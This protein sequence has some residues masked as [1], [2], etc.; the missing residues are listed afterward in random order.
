ML[1]SSSITKSKRINSKKLRFDLNLQNTC[2]DYEITSALWWRLLADDVDDLG[3]LVEDQG[4][5]GVLDLVPDFLGVL[6]FGAEKSV[7]TLSHPE[8]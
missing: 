6:S 5:D 4:P 3:F 8:A 2:R 1:R 7:E